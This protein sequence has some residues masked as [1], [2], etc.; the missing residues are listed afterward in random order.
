MWRERMDGA[1]T[2]DL[3][4]SVLPLCPPAAPI[5]YW[6][7]F[8]RIFSGIGGVDFFDLSF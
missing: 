6:G 4:I 8:W 5:Q 1:I 3:P 2:V 7:P